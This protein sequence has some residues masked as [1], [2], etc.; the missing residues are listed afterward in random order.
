MSKPASRS[1]YVPIDMVHPYSG[2]RM[3]IK[4]RVTKKGDMRTW[5]N[6]RGDGKLFSF[7]LLD[8]AG[9]AIKVTAFN[10]TADA[11]FARVT[12]GC[13]YVVGNFQLKPANARFNATGHDYEISMNSDS[14]CEQT[15]DDGA[16]LKQCFAFTSIAQM[17]AVAPN[18]TVDVIGVVTSV[19]D[20][21]VITTKKGNSLTKRVI[22]LLD[23]SDKAIDVTLWGSQAEKYDDTALAGRP[24]VAV[25]G[26]KVSDYGGRCLTASFQSQ[27]FVN[28]EHPD[29]V[30]LRTW[31]DA[32]VSS[33]AAVI[34]SL[35]TS[36]G[37]G[38]S[39]DPRL[40]L[41]DIAHIDAAT[42]ASNSGEY[43]SVMATST[44]IRADMDKPPYYNACSQ[45]GCQKKVHGEPGAW[46]CDKCDV[47]M[48]TCVPRFILSVRMSD[49]SG[50][51]WMTAF[52]DAAT[53]IL[54]GTSAQDLAA[55]KDAGDVDGWARVFNRAKFQT[56]V[57]KC[58]A[59]EERDLEGGMHTKVTVMRVQTPNYAREA[60]AI[61]E[62][63]AV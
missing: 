48:E 38:S 22:Q 41:S 11:L 42:L 34:E 50:E 23:S 12:E 40:Q 7:D 58:R 35:S 54:G 43:F 19:G 46:R 60:N 25:K 8:T 15:Q 57:L 59:K 31:F 63:L 33:S 21:N 6:A 17:E 51:Q 29:A 47:Q 16:I 49:A 56:M 2:G 28:P 9:G 32:R 10:K 27:V 55:M 4:G 52:N 61:L 13:V 53:V 3:T 5:S 20:A 30:A 44:A 26:C 45:A 14:K 18:A 62:Q 37:G 1:N 39:N 24:T 36:G